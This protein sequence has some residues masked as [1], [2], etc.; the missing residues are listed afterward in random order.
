MARGYIVFP[1]KYGMRLNELFESKSAPLYHGTELLFLAAIVRDD[2]LSAGVNW[3]RVG[4]PNGP[5]LTRNYRVAMT[6]AQD[7]EFGMGGVLVLDQQKISQ[8]HRIQP[9]ADVDAQGQRWSNEFEEVPLV[10]ELYPLSRYLVSINVDPR[11]IRKVMADKDLMG[12]RVAE[13]PSPMSELFATFDECHA[14]LA[15]LLHHPKLNASVP[16]GRWTALGWRY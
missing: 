11:H 15:N 10:A 1:S 13:D 4:E 14:A 16:H 7:N 5:R 8:R 3:G 12:F 6:F 2:T 9:Y